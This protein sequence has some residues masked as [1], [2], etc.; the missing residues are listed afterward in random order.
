MVNGGPLPARYHHTP[1]CS[2]TAGATPT[3][4]ES[5]DAGEREVPIPP[6]AA[7]QDGEVL[8]AVVEELVKEEVQDA[9]AEVTR[10]CVEVSSKWRGVVLQISGSKHTTLTKKILCPI[11]SETV[12]ISWIM[13]L[14]GCE[15][16]WSLRQFSLLQTQEVELAHSLMATLEDSIRVFCEEV[17]LEVSVWESCAVAQEA[18]EELR[19]ILEGLAREEGERLVESVMLEAVAVTARSVWT[20]ADSLLSGTPE[21]RPP[22]ES[23]SRTL[24]DLVGKPPNVGGGNSLM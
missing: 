14:R 16:E 11:N 22:P 5:V 17:V 1:H 15:L 19:F 4:V 6:P 24:F 3:F 20:A 7:Y 2:F 21:M 13:E 8:V 18:V 9:C 23:V 10:E 12:L